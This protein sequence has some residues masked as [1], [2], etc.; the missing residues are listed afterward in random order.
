[1]QFSEASNDLAVKMQDA[2]ALENDLEMFALLDSDLS[3]ETDGLGNGDSQS[4]F[5]Y[6]E[7]V[8]RFLITD[9]NNAGGSAKAQS[10]IW[11]V[12]DAVSITVSSFN[13]VPG[14]AN[15]LYMDG[16]VDFVKY[17][18]IGPVNKGWAH[19]ANGLFDVPVANANAN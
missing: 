1:M 3:V 12:H 16:H 17:P 8:E 10:A 13:H 2:G 18:G 5:R 19:V 11:L 9:I 14:G 15:V 6:R 7:G 4:I